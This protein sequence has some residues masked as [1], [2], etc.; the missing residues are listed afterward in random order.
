MPFVQNQLLLRSFLSVLAV[1]MLASCGGVQDYENFE[2]YDDKDYEESTNSKTKSDSYEE[3]SF[4]NH[5]VHFTCQKDNCHD[6][7]TMILSST[8]I[9]D[10][11]MSACSSTQISETLIITNEHCVK[12]HS[13]CEN[14]Q[15]FMPRIVDTKG[16]ILH[17]ARQV[18]CSRIVS[19]AKDRKNTHMQDYAILEMDAAI[20][21]RPMARVSVS[22]VE[23][24]EM[25]SYSSS[26]ASVSNG[27]IYGRAEPQNNCLAVMNTLM[28]P[29]YDDRLAPIAT[30]VGC[31]P[32]P[33]NSGSSLRNNRGEIVALIQAGYFF[34]AEE[35]AIKSLKNLAD[36]TQMPVPATNLSCV[37][38]FDTTTLEAKSECARRVEFS[39]V[40]SMVRLKAKAAKHAE[41]MNVGTDIVDKKLFVWSWRSVEKTQGKGL[42]VLR[43]PVCLR[44]EQS[45]ILRGQERLKHE[46]LPSIEV[47]FNE[48]LQAS[49]G[50]V[51]TRNDLDVEI[52]ALK[53]CSEEQ[54]RGF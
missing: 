30:V 17:H 9:F 49:Y 6:G 35:R 27:E 33:G 18:G 2:E 53:V 7:Q 12:D 15:F 21:G 16:N 8:G 20:K 50:E 1:S 37:D 11:S 51:R 54:E 26:M 40:D 46:F 32:I 45:E 36:V 4:K 44:S 31:K 39:K 52:E 25:L 22:G 29:D 3:M 24:N 47:S 5:P 42:L 10:S 43:Y 41:S 48:K 14:M 28:A 23:N 19:I 38:P 13:S 34:D